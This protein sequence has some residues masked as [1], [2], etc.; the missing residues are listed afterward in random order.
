MPMAR[1][2][3]SLFRRE[4]ECH[5]LSTGN[6]SLCG[7]TAGIGTPEKRAR[8]KTVLGTLEKRDLGTLTVWFS[9][10]GVGTVG[11][12]YYKSC[13]DSREECP[14]W[15]SKFPLPEVSSSHLYF[16]MLCVSMLLRFQRRHKTWLCTNVLFK[17]KH[18]LY[19]HWQYI[20]LLKNNILKI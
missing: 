17:Q 5:S 12:L 11:R 7:M 16:S 1:G 6:F 19:K 15:S 20:H 8:P 10:T 2:H 18:I 3:A 13:W 4:G 14:N 9:M